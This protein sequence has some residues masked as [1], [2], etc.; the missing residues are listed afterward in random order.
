MTDYFA[1]ARKGRIIALNLHQS[2]AVMFFPED[3]EEPVASARPDAEQIMTQRSK[4]MF[5]RS[6]ATQAEA[7]NVPCVPTDGRVAHD[8]GAVANVL[9]L[10]A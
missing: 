10:V 9:R 5:V 1:K 7:A 6:D 2:G 8:A 3:M 4:A